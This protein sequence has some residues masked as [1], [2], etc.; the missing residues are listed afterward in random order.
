MFSFSK[1]VSQG[2]AYD[3]KKAETDS[4]T[5]AK[6][7]I[8]V[9]KLEELKTLIPLK[10]S[11]NRQ[12]IIDLLK[13][14]FDKD[15]IKR[16][17]F[18]PVIT[19]LLME[20]FKQMFQG[21]TDVCSIFTDGNLEQTSNQINPVDKSIKY[22]N[23]L[24]IENLL[25]LSILYET[26][27]TIYS[28]IIQSDANDKPK[29]FETFYSIP[30]GQFTNFVNKIEAGVRLLFLSKGLQPP[31]SI[32]ST[33]KSMRKD[34]ESKFGIPNSVGSIG[35]RTR[36]YRKGKRST[37]KRSRLA[38]VTKRYKRYKNKSKNQKRI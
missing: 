9:E 23:K 16:T 10:D 8:A 7:D 31:F 28:K 13:P 37:T 30:K 27:I 11:D 32:S 2:I 20:I 21:T 12:R 6:Y 18:R 25:A 38:K 1:P 36:R 34:K 17:D 19:N 33:L 22:V 5:K 4:E 26:D 3:P 29:T 35:G 24:I 14:C 15:I